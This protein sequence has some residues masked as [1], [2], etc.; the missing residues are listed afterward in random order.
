ME[1]LAELAASIGRDPAGVAHQAREVA[2]DARETGQWGR[3]SSAQAVLGR[4]LRM[5]GEIELAG[6]ALEEAVSAAQQAGDD[7]LAADAHLALAGVMS[8]AGRSTS[9]FIHLDHADR[10]GSEEL[11]GIA[12]LQRALVCRDVGRFDEALRLFAD[13]IPRLRRESRWLDLARVLAN[14]ASIRAR[15]GDV[16]AAIG[17]YEEA[18]RLY[19]SVDQEF[20]ALQARHDLAWTLA[21]VGDLPRA[22]QLFDDV[23]KSFI[24]LGH[25]ASLPLLSRAE[26]LLMG[27]L[28]ADALAFSQDA[29]RR[30]DAEGNRS[31]AAEALVAVAEAGRLEGDFATA[32]DAAQRAQEW[33]AANQSVGW[34]RTA[35]LEAMRSQFERGGLDSPAVARLEEIAETLCKAGDV[36]SEIHARCLAALASCD[37]HQLGRAA[38]QA[39]L[40]ARAASRSRSLQTRLAS[41]HAVATVRLAQGDLDGARRELRKALVTLDEAR[42]LRGVGDVGTAVLTQARSITRLAGRMATRETQPMRALAW[43]E[44]ARLAGWVS[45]PALVPASDEA[46]AD[47]SGLR[48]IA[49]DLRRAELAG[50]PTEELRRRH[51]ALEQSM[52]AEWLKRGT[53]GTSANAVPPL[54][55][56]KGLLGDCQIVSIVSTGTSS[57]DRLA[58]VTVDRRR[59][60][61][62]VL[63]DPTF[64]AALAQRA[65]VALR[66]L[67]NKASA[68]QI[69]AARQRAFAA[70]VESLDTALLAPLRIEA[71]HVVLVVP[72]ELY[73][74]PWAAMSSL[75]GRS[76]TLAPSVRWW[77][78]GV[79]TP[80]SPPRSA[81]VVAG[82]RL[83]EAQSE[84][85]SVAACHRRSTLLTDATAT[86]ANVR[87]SMPRHDVVHLV[88]H[89]RFRHDNPLW[90]TI[91]LADGQLTVYELQQLATVPATVI[92]AS[93]DSGIGGDRGGA[94]LQGLAGTLLSMGARTVVAAVGALPDTAETREAMVALHRDLVDGLAPSESLARQRVAANDA[95]SPTVAGL[96]TLGVG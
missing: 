68:P 62:V 52:R 73:A 56:L 84:A 45:H 27:G 85:R 49:S 53:E 19:L 77:M 90:S 60:T 1:Q 16:D 39:G 58:A 22:L 94:Q 71:G 5:L 67:A 61:S 23:T 30:L 89:G 14:R 36:R 79:S 76:F 95:F 80:S 81:L 66:G 26:A 86:T 69:A 31:A 51:A 12:V 15:R 41:R 4:A 46:T 7:E 34:A 40:A 96:V 65:D 59:A 21:N 50:E 10:L 25:D 72:A 57:S 43:M 13:A 93:C 74:I 87:M 38:K 48:M 70:A 32:L 24:D 42:Q 2:A 3:L 55:E 63:S 11:R 37:D 35:E 54:S 28:S 33:F 82:P 64:V 9:A 88:A 47:F 78:G 18:E 92:L 91:E 44:R 8:I 75:K 83:S 6:D 20:A 29:A 17:D